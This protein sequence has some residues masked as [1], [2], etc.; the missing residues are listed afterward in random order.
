MV[1]AIINAEDVPIVSLKPLSERK[2][3]QREHERI[4]AS[5]EAVG[6]I[7][8][9]IIFQEGES[10]L[11]LDGVQRYHILVE[12]GVET[13]PCIIRREKETFTCNRMVN[14]ISPVQQSRMI[15]K[16]L[17]EL[18]EKTIASALGLTS[19]AHR[20]SKTLISQLHPDVVKALDAENITKACAREFTFIKQ[21]RQLEILTV[22]KANN[23]FSIAF[24]RALILK[25]PPKQRVKKRRNT[26]SPWNRAERKK[27][28]LLTKLQDAEQKHDFYSRLYRQYSVD[29]LKLV[30]YARSLITNP[31]VREHLDEHHPAIVSQFTDIIAQAQ[32]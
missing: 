3:T 9:L 24:A 23:D 29:L 28:Q 1:N 15:E 12:M 17:G 10:F 18:D 25:T 20:L 6:L 31:I 16:S 14:H 5:I 19:I 2:I 11:I 8:P 32:A 26:I 4:R 7:E 13:V 21:E 27:N 22:M 30:I